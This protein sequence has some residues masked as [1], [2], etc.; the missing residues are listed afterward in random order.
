MCFTLLKAPRWV[1][2]AIAGLI[3][4]VVGIFLPQIFGVGYSTI[5]QI[6]NGQT[7]SLGLLI[8][9]LIAKLILTPVSIG[10]GFP[11]GVFAPSLF[12]GST[13]GGGLRLDRAAG[14]P[15]LP[16]RSARPSRWWAWPPCWRAPCMRP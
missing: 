12:L 2:P 11:G 10:G 5:E 16:D 8:A 9:L 4:G 13:L 6:L 3:V 15:G 14:D 1:K 7:F